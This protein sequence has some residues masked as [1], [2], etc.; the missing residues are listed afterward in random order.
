M[1]WKSLSA[2]VR[3]LHP[4]AIMLLMILSSGCDDNNDT[5]AGQGISQPSNAD[6]LQGQQ[7]AA[8]AG[9]INAPVDGST[10]PGTGDLNELGGNAN[11]NQN[12]LR[13]RFG[14]SDPTPAMLASWEEYNARLTAYS[15]KDV[16]WPYPTAAAQ[17]WMGSTSN[18]DPLAVEGTTVAVDFDRIPRGSL[19]YIPALN[20][21]AEANDTGATGLWSRSDASQSDYGPDGG[22]RIDVF[23]LAGDRSSVQVE[24]DFSNAVSSNEY[25]KIYVV[26]A[27][28]GWKH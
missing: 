28:P 22:G 16:D 13:E 14:L 9:G 18:G 12:A 27:G 8:Q 3:L 11:Q 5:E 7:I 20:M 4:A 19:I 21:Y 1:P 15:D 26:H 17:N 25:G 2:P 24:R 10:A 23:N 6:L